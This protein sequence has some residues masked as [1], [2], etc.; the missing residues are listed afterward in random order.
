MARNVLKSSIQNASFSIIFQVGHY[1]F[2]KKTRIQST[3]L[4]DNFQMYI[5]CAKRLHYQNCRPRCLGHHER[6]ATTTRIHYPIP[7][8]R[9][10][11]KGLFNERKSS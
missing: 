10:S 6:P 11:A 9:A 2:I 1:I 3:A 8:K 4:L 7:F 5:F